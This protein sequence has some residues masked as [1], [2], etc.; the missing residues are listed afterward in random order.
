MYHNQPF[1]KQIISHIIFFSALGLVSCKQEDKTIKPDAKA[2]IKAPAPLNDGKVS[3]EL[4]IP[5]SGLEKTF[6]LNCADNEVFVIIR[7]NTDSSVNFYETNNSYGYQNYTFIIKSKDSSFIITKAGTGIWKNVPFLNTVSPHESL[8][9]KFNL[10]NTIC[11]YSPVKKGLK[12]TVIRNTDSW[13]GMPDRPIDHATIQVKYELPKE[14][15]YNSFLQAIM[16][17]DTLSSNI[18]KLNIIKN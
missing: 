2:A 4:S 6:N 18:L 11:Y 15:I 3:L 12:R 16:F 17:S 14:Y 5:A 13:N 8:I 10:K 1:L 7:N 9:L